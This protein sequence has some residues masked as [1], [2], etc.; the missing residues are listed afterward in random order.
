MKNQRNL[1][2]KTKRNHLLIQ[3]NRFLKKV[4]IKMSFSKSKNKK[5]MK[6]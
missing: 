1:P 5:K 2:T 6:N 3:I 4:M